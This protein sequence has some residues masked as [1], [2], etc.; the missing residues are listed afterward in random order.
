M[1]M[2]IKKCYEW[3]NTNAKLLFK[4]TYSKSKL[5]IGILWYP[6]KIGKNHSKYFHFIYKVIVEWKCHYFTLTFRNII[7]F[8]N[9]LELKRCHVKDKPYEFFI[10]ILFLQIHNE[11]CNYVTI[12]WRTLWFNT[13]TKKLHHLNPQLFE[14]WVCQ[15]HYY[16]HLLDFYLIG[17]RKMS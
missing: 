14:D 13:L 2:F 1:H 8:R 17:K 16:C 12:S 3:T 15:P 4:N 10:Q 11:N 6:A 7:I 5:V 9:T